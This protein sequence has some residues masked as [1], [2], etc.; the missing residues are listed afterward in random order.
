MTGNRYNPL[1][2]SWLPTSSI[3]AP[4]ARALH[5]AVWT[6]RE[7]IVWGD[8]E[9]GGRYDPSTD[10]WNSVSTNSSP[11]DRAYHCFAWTG[12]ELIVWGGVGNGLRNDGGRYNPLTDT[13][14]L[15]ALEPAPS[16][17]QAAFVVWI[18]DAMIIF[19]GWEGGN[20]YVQATWCYKP[21]SPFAGD[22]LSDDWQESNFGAAFTSAAAPASDPDRDGQNNRFEFCAGTNPRDPNSRF[23]LLMDAAPMPLLRFFPT[24]PGRRYIPLWS[25]NLG[26]HG[27][28][29]LRGFVT[30]SDGHQ[31]TILDTNKAALFKFYRILLDIE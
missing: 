21:P 16:P 1:T 27:F 4:A 23:Q 20:E 5:S 12:S 18:G 11:S 13:W 10:S 26:R 2:D 15:T 25:T 29:P 24:M 6:G 7:M 17:R 9:Q 28:E 8:G 14:T 31:R 22:G 3:G 30:V 19:G